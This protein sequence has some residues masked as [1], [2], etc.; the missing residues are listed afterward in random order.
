[1]EKVWHGVNDFEKKWQDISRRSGKDTYVREIVEEGLDIGYR[2][3]V[4][5]IIVVYFTIK[6]K[7]KAKV[8]YSEE[9]R[10]GGE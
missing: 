4:I 10:E 3:V 9:N 5:N 1:M 2:T 8:T 7:E 6:L